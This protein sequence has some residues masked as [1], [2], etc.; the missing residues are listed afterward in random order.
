MSIRL[1]N[2]TFNFNQNITLEDAF[3]KANDI[4]AAIAMVRNPF[5]I[6]QVKVYNNAMWEVQ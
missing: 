3:K 1:N 5:D 6:M 2:T 4:L